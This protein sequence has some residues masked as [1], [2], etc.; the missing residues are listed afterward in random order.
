MK[1]IKNGSLVTVLMPLLLVAASLTAKAQTGVAIDSLMRT[2]QWKQK[3]NP[4][5][6]AADIITRWQG[7]EERFRAAFAWTAQNIRYDLAALRDNKLYNHQEL[8]SNALR[9]RMALCEGY[10][11]VLDSL[12]SLMGIETFKVPGYTRW[13][14]KLQPE[15]H[16]W[17][18]V[19]LGGTWYLSDPTW[20]SG[21]IVNG[22][23]RADYD[24]LWFMKPPEK[25]IHSHMPYDPIWQLLPQPLTHRGFVNADGSTLP[26][27]WQFNDSIAVY[28]QQGILNQHLAEL[29]RIRQG[30]SHQSL[31]PRISFLEQSVKVQQH[32]AVVELMRQS[33][34]LFNAAVGAYNDAVEAY[35]SR[36][37]RKQVMASLIRA[38]Q[39]LESAG[40]M[41]PKQNVPDSLRD[42]LSLMRRQIRELEAKLR[43]AESKWY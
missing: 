39:L 23:Y 25:M 16:L 14:G 24:T 43:E 33:N 13:Q 30:F 40:A 26:G 15:P 32:N 36:K 10:V 34:S 27:N 2:M 7:E 37:P 42:E 41:L 38:G 9:K 28:L 17:I 31:Q 20:A 11:A 35:N 4:E 22:R 21:G 8:V 3:N 19:Q 6:I 1:A 29:R 5:R 18:A 12:C